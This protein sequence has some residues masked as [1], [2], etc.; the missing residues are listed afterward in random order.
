MNVP[1]RA[2]AVSGSDVYAGGDFTSAGG[3]P[4]R[5]CCQMGRDGMVA[6]WQRLS[7][8][9]VA[10]AVLGGELYAGGY[11]TTSGGTPVNYVAKWTGTVWSAVGGGANNPVTSLAVSGTDLYAGGGFTTAGGIPA[12]RIAKWDGTAWSALGSGM[13]SAVWAVAVS[14]TDVYVG[15]DF[16]TAGGIPALRIAKWD[17]TAWSAFGSGVSNTVNSLAVSGT[18]PLRRRRIHHGG[19][20]PSQSYRQ[21]GW[22]GMVGHRRGAWAALRMRWPYRQ[23][24]STWAAISLRGLPRVERPRPLFSEFLHGCAGRRLEHRRKLERRIGTGPGADVTT[25]TDIIVSADVSIRDLRI[26]A[27]KTITV[28]SGATLTVSGNLNVTDGFINGPGHVVITNCDT[29][30]V[31]GGGST[32][33]IFTDL[34]RCV[35][36][37]GTFLFSRRNRGGLWPGR[38]FEHYRHG[39][40]RYHTAR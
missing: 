40:R 28:A 8:Q 29:G 13:D 3:L 26:D 4:G 31:S 15:G 9:V 6:A 23:T 27:G 21:M 18:D 25:A 19:R 7:N 37:T 22:N 38:S 30:A 1:V 17:G 11:F 2:V 24:R 35:N 33:M 14:G 16:A 10:L 12:N 34:T 32:G 36:D 5:S 20:D 39:Q